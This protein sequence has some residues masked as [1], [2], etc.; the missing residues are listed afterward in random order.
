MRKTRV[1]GQLMG[2]QGMVIGDVTMQPDPDGDGEV[3]VVSVRPDAR[4][5]GRCAQCRR[6]CP[7]YDAG[8]GTRRWRT[9]D[10]GTTRT[11][12]E[13]AAPRVQCPEHGVLVAHVPWARPGAKCTY[14]LEDTCAWLAKNMALTAVTVFLRL[15]W[16]T[17]AAI[18]ARVVQ[19]LTGK[20]DQLDG[21]TRIGIDEISYRKGHRYLTCVVDHDTGRLVWAREGRNKDTL[22]S[23]FQDLGG[24]QIGCVDACVG[25]RRGVD[26]RGG[27]G[28]RT[29]GGALPGSV[30][31]GC[32]G[33]QGV[34]QGSPADPGPGRR[35]E[36]QRPLGGHQE[37]VRPDPG[38]AWH[39]GPDQDHEHRASIDRHFS[40][41]ALHAAF[42]SHC[43][44]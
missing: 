34:G 3:L 36:P 19:D 33:D 25:R 17:V 10:T 18:V 8:V 23:F 22:S 43:L 14:L 31:R 21:L 13:A 32:V 4:S 1:F 6:S 24:V 42:E 16:R 44:G 26:P 30:S 7:G 11:F 29:A 38:A 20:I 9:V 41:T 35:R 27:E 2:V 5:G 39:P 28:A 40:T 15:S 37:S 12:L